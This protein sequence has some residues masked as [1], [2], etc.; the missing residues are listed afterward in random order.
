MSNIRDLTGSMAGALEPLT[1]QARTQ[2]GLRRRISQTAFEIKGEN[3][4]EK[5]IQEV[6]A[7]MKNRSPN[8]PQNAFAGESFNVGGGGQLPAKAVRLDDDDSKLWSGILD[9]TDKEVA[10]RT[11]VTEVTVGQKKDRTAFGVRLFN[12]TRG[13]DDPFVPSRPGLIH[14]LLTE[15]D[16]QDEGMPLSP[17]MELIETEEDFEQF[18]HLLVAPRRTLPLI[19]M[20][21]LPGI[22]PIFDPN[23]LCKKVSGLAHLVELS[24]DMSWELTNRVGKSLSVYEGATRVYL[25]GFDPDEATPFDHALW[26]QR[27]SDTEEE[28]KQRLEQVSAWVFNQSLRSKRIPNFPHYADVR[29]WSNERQSQALKSQGQPDAALLALY[30]EENAELKKSI[31][32]QKPEYDALLMQADKERNEA[33]A[34][35]KEA[36]EESHHLRLRVETLETAL[37]GINQSLP[38]EPLKQY[39]DFGTWANNHLTGSIWIAQKALRAMK[40]ADFG[41]IEK[42]GKTLIGLRDFY[43]PMRRN[44]S[45]SQREKYE[46]FLKSLSLEDSKCFSEQ[47]RIKNFPE[48]KLTR[49]GEDLWCH[50]H[51]KYGVSQNTREMFRIYYHW[52]EE[53][54]ILLIGHMPTHLDNLKT[55]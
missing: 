20:S 45:L 15:L 22:S 39:S 17:K 19:V 52:H 24:P 53:E 40:K 13:D 21:D 44:S 9:D 49:N 30:E 33:E 38:D 37:R 34:M 55:N 29:S 46:N 16:A 2:N 27:P 4:F 8:I 31:E 42:I 1:R 41:D 26:L 6:V 23:L 3:A 11:W 10:R 35:A 50:D 18:W 48:Y 14:T 7:W 25:P 36:R 5:A 54:Q 28:R 47:N 51:I 43:V 12:L 32:E